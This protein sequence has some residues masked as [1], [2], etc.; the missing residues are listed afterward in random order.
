MGSKKTLGLFTE[1]RREKAKFI[2]DIHGEIL[3]THRPSVC[4]PLAC[5]PVFFP[6]DIHSYYEAYGDVETTGKRTR[7]L[8]VFDWLRTE[9]L[10]GRSKIMAVAEIN[11]NSLIQHISD[12][13]N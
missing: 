11:L 2:H 5:I 13:Y 9:E 7:G 4:D 8:L 12:S 6:E 3:K 10:P 1:E